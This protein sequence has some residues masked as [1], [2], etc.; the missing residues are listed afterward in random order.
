MKFAD[1]IIASS[2]LTVGIVFPLGS[3]VMLYQNHRHLLNS[4]I[5]RISNNQQLE[6]FS[7]E[8][9]LLQDA[10]DAET[11]YGKD[12]DKMNQRAISYLQQHLH[13]NP[14][15]YVTVYDQQQTI[16]Y[17]NMKKAFVSKNHVKEI[18]KYRIIALQDQNYVIMNS[19]I[20]AG[21]M[22]YTLSTGYNI[23]SCYQERTRQ[24]HSFLMIDAC[25]LLISFLIL[26]F[27][28]RYIT[29]P[30]QKL[31]KASQ[32]IAKG[33]YDERT[34]IHVNDEIG[35]LSKSFDDMAEAVEI[36][37]LELK[38]HAASREEFMGSFSHEI[39]TPM[40]AI[41]GFA[42]MLRTIDCDEETRRK[43]ASY[44]YTE[45]KRLENLS[46]T[47]M[48]LLAL[49]ELEPHLSE[50]SISFGMNALKQYYDGIQMD[51]NLEFLCDEG[52]VFS[53]PDLFFTLLR[54]LI[55]NAIKASNKDQTVRIKGVCHETFYQITIQ[56]EGIGMGEKDID[57]AA[58]PFYMA[59]KSRSRQSGGAGLGLSIVKR[60]L[61]FHHAKLVITSTPGKGTTVSFTLEVIPHEK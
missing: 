33:H 35:E 13:V 48:D 22:T 54:N 49:N 15:S 29:K 27:M 26:H 9:K 23:T 46:H 52:K 25:I 41:L 38:Q 59:D 53:Q 37:V 16:L 28:S 44:I 31:N 60:I 57:M 45:G 61:D 39:K 19:K 3:T 24:L 5:E 50:F 10:L 1:K 32:R 12:A 2:I 40:T 30:I 14:N 8:S 11:D 58:Q 21:N 18:D 56:D 42:D 7:L 6:N 51:N 20:I 17:S 36:N 4:T 43:A 55:D 34:N 47:L